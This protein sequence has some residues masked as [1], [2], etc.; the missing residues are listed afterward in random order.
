MLTQA[1]RRAPEPATP[2][3]DPPPLIRRGKAVSLSTAVTLA[4]AAAGAEL[5]GALNDRAMRYTVA[6]RRSGESLIEALAE[7]ATARAECVHGT[8]LIFLRAVGVGEDVAQRQIEIHD[9]IQTD[10]ELA[11]RVRAG[12]VSL[13]TGYEIMKASPA[14]QQ[15][16]MSRSIAAPAPTRAEIRA[17]KREANTA[18]ARYLDVTPEPAGPPAAKP[19][20]PCPNCGQ[21][22][23][24]VYGVKGSTAHCQNCAAPPTVTLTVRR[25]DLVELRRL[26]EAAVATLDDGPYE[27]LLAAIE[28]AT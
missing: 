6:M 10:P 24:Q 4:D 23:K 17:L 9:R 13:S 20:P 18:P 12:W 28:S 22:A 27:R 1:Y 25:D 19:A 11:A 15:E 26:V 16:I 21:P 14:V 3:A 2:E 8:W 5:P 7:L